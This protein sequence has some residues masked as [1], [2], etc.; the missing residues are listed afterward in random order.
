MIMF[1][2]EG[3][4]QTAKRRPPIPMSTRL[5]DFLGRAH[6]ERIN[7]YVLDNKVDVKS[8]L[9]RVNRILDIEGVTPHT[10]RHTWATRAAEDGVAMMKIAQF[11]GDTVQTV[12]KN[13]LHLSPDYLR[14]VVDRQPRTTH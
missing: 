13:Y 1:L 6:D 3:E 4:L 12:E 7:E 11:L 9:D 5:A 2:P 14:D 10:F 8:G